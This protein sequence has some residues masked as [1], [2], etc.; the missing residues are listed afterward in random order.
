MY[1]IEELM[2]YFPVVSL[3]FT[4]EGVSLQTDN[5]EDKNYGKSNGSRL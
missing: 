1:Q 2:C 5:Q 3:L 4:G